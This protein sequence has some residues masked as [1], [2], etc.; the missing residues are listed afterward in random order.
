MT[1]IEPKQFLP[2]VDIIIILCCF[3]KILIFCID[4]YVCVSKVRLLQSSTG[5]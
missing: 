3:I 4:M 5:P 2:S 1:N